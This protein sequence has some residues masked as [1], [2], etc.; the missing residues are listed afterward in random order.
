MDDDHLCQHNRAAE[1]CWDC[2]RAR[3]AALA[4]LV[5]SLGDKLLVLAEHLSMLAERKEVRKG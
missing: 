5:M 2:Q 4:K 1:W 3:N